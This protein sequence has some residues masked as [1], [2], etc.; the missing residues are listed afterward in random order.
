MKLISR[1]KALGFSA[2]LLA[3]TMLG[4]AFLAPALVRDADARPIVVTP[5]L[6]APVSF[7]DL[8]ERVSPA[9]VS[10]N[11]IAEEKLP[12]LPG[13]ME[14]FFEFFRNRPGFEDYFND[15]RGGEDEDGSPRTRES[16]SLG[17]GF[18]ISEVGHIVTNN[19]VVAKAKEIEV[20]LE[21]GRELKAEL[22]GTDEKTDLAVL[23]VIEPGVYPYVEFETDTQL[24]RGDWVIAL[25]NPF[26]F[27]GTATAGIVSADGRQLRGGGPYTDFLQIDAAINRG[28]S[29]GPTFDLQGRVVGVNTAIISPTGGSVGIGFAIPAE[30]AQKI[31]TQLI[32]KGKVVR[33]WLGVSIQS[34][35]KDMASALGLAEG[36]TGALVRQV[37]I[38]SPAQKSGFKV[39]DIIL[40]I[41]GRGMEDS[42]E[43]TRTVGGMLANSKH[44]F[45]IWRD[46]KRTNLNVTIGELPDNVEELPTDDKPAPEVGVSGRVETT[47]YL[48][49]TLST[50]TDADRRRLGLD[51]TD[52]GILVNSVKSGTA[53]GRLLTSGQAI[54]EAN[55][56]PV[57]SPEEFKSAVEEARNMGREKIL[58]SVRIGKDTAVVPLDISKED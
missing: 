21:D 43:V 23:K 18:F 3:G 35:D 15:P 54:L 44:E 34:F 17:S 22:I 12:E 53:A 38:D 4:G 42:T 25:G 40:K 33:G 29:G 27:G 9:V 37:V 1:T 50:I 45:Q 58:V 5:P 19:H 32:E 10:V 24:R 6:G 39:N 14:E 11:V 31:T 55:F 2:A 36:E 7:A 48:G 52:G 46:G 41:D 56:E 16:R 26:G 51:P 28:N 57:T 20:V 13:G 8:V 30:Q 47:N 49:M